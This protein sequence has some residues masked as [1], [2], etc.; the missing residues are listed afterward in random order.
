MPQG[1]MFP[2][3]SVPFG[4]VQLSPDTY[5]DGCCAGYHYTH[6]TIIGFSHTHLSGT[7]CADYGDVLFMPAVGG[8]NIMPGTEEDP[9]SG[10][11]LPLQPRPGNYLSGVL[12]R[13]AR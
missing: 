6:N 11:P 13:H 8:I 5:N 4:G 1:N 2:G 12:Q 7:G 10:I 9:D 3:P